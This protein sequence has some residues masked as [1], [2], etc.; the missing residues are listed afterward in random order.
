MSQQH[1]RMFAK[2]ITWNSYVNLARLAVRLLALT[3]LA[4]VGA[5]A[6]TRKPPADPPHL[7]ATITL[8]IGGADES[9]DAYIFGT[10]D[11]LATD[12]SGRIIVADSKDNTIRVFTADGRFVYSLGR[13]GK[14]PGDL[15]RPCCLTIAKD[16][17]LWVKEYANRRYSQFRLG[18]TTATYV[19]S[20][21]GTANSVWASDRVDFDN[22]GRIVD[23]A[24]A[25]DATTK[26]FRIVRLRVDSGGNVVASDTVPKPPADSLSDVAIPIPG[27]TSSQAQPFGA[28]E[29]HAY[30]ANG[31]AAHAVSSRYAV[32]W[33]SANGTRRALLERPSA[34]APALSD[35]ERALAEKTLNA[36]ARS[37]GIPR[38][39][40]PLKIPATQT[41]LNALGFDLDG[42]LWIERSVIDGQP[43]QAD[44][45]ERN[46]TWSAV[47]QWPANV[48]L[49]HWT[50]RGRSGLAI[51]E[52]ED[53]V[54]RVVR[55]AFR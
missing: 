11:G 30:G 27:G 2:P 3:T 40:L 41:P 29:L 37:T 22:K 14:G 21:R 49:H 10:I 39:N 42:R 26:R 31:E 43:N 48:K 5:G 50:V 18:P 25:Y 15:D 19:R 38:A 13:K 24:S 6:Q 7:T 54:Q 28:R 36:I 44:V 8:I 1:D 12:A 53:G 17:T 9:R 46:G 20:V 51:A 52:D 23:L 34:S 35:S 32:L 33:V 4:T 47:M 55:I 16:G 45:Y